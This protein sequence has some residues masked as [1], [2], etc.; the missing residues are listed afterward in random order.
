MY[1]HNGFDNEILENRVIALGFKIFWGKNV[2]DYSF[3]DYI[4]KIFYRSEWKICR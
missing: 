1:S 4:F 3:I 2:I